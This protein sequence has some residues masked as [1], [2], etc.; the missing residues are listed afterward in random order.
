M[1]CVSCGCTDDQACEG[2]CVW[3]STDPPVCSRCADKL[4]P[5]FSEKIGGALIDSARISVMAALEAFPESKIILP[6]EM[7]DDPIV[8][9]PTLQ[10]CLAQ[11]MEWLNLARV[12]SLEQSGTPPTSLHV[13]T[14]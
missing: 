9:P 7:A 2:G 8:D 10:A 11:A 4:T 13:V 12:R 14:R 1:K 3:L 5:M 6:S